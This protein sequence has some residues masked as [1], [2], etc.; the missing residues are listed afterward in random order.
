MMRHDWFIGS[1]PVSL[2]PLGIDDVT[3]DYVSWLNDPETTKDTEQSGMNHDRC[4]VAAYVETNLAAP[5]SALWKISVEGRHVGN[6][7]LSGF[8]LP[9]HRG[10]IA[11]IIGHSTHRGRGIGTEA[12]RLL[13]GHCFSVMG[14]HKLT[15]GIYSTNI[16][17]RRAFEKAS[18]HLEATLKSHACRDGRFIDVWQMAR[19]AD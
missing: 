3:D 14:L 9:H 1:G 8:G 19:F 2:A 15:A 7:R 10:Q 12:V 13:S 4:S 18:F 11:L 5:Q 16:G 17:S 6:I